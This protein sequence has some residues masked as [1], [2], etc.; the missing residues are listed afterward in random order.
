MKKIF[1]ITLGAL[2]LLPAVSCRRE[3]ISIEEARDAKKQEVR[4]TA[5]V[6]GYEVK[7]YDFSF[8]TGDAIGIFAFDQANVKANVSGATVAPVTPIK[9]ELVRKADFVAYYPYDPSFKLD[10]KVSFTVKTDQR[11]ADAFRNSD[12]KLAVAE[13]TNGETVALPFRHL[14]AKLDIVVRSADSSEKATAIT[15]GPVATTVSANLATETI[16]AP[17]GSASVQ[18]FKDGDAFSAILVPQTLSSLPLTI[19]TS[20]GRTVSLPVNTQVQLLTNKIT[21]ITVDLTTGPEAT[22]SVS[23][24]D[25]ADGGSM[26]F[27]K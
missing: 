1:A 21:T 7:A 18:A 25:W 5:S 17:S 13:G 15:F 10:D 27:H 9:W 14:L 26:N 23:I 20:R 6:A 16:D 22:F 11:G 12:L 3:D 4:F 2:F 8:V 24:T 19:T